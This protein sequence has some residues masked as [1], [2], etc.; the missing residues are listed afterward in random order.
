MVGTTKAGSLRGARVH[1]I[2]PIGEAIAQFRSHLQ[3]QAGFARATRSG[4][5]QQSY[6]F[7]TEQALHRRQFLLASNQRSELDGQVVGGGVEVLRG[8]K[9]EGRPAMTS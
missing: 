5:G 6:V 7:T 8:G 9:S 1:E 2:H 4:Q 3:A